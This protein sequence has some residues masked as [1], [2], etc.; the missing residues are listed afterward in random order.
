MVAVY[1]SVITRRGDDG[2]TDFMFGRRCSKNSLRVHAYGEVDELNA[3]L[4]LARALGLSRRAE[5]LVDAVQERLTGLMGEL[6]T[7]PP[8]LPAYVQRGL[9]RITGDDVAWAEDE[10]HALEQGEGIRF[11]GWVRPGA[12]ATPG[13]AQLDVARAVCR[14]AERSVLALH[15]S[16]PI[17]NASLLTFL[18]RVSDLLWLAARYDTTTTK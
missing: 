17:A 18:N 5:A 3:A 12:G 13:A 4:G 7:L 15:E 6:A 14:R 2:Q 8:D 11:A 9:P 1:M 16:E 10:A